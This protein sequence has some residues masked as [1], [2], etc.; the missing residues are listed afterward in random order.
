M[1][2]EATPVEPQPLPPIEALY[3][4]VRSHRMVL[5]GMAIHLESLQGEVGNLQAGI[6]Q[7]GD[8]MEDYLAAL[9]VQKEAID[10][11]APSA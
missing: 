11:G 6:Q 3:A 4:E 5:Q 1:S 2:N 7:M 9:A 8:I 10:G